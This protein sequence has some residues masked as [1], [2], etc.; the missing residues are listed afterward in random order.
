MDISFVWRQCSGQTARFG[1]DAPALGLEDAAPLSYGD[2]ATRA[3]SYANA[4]LE[5]GVGR[6]DRVALLLYNSVEYLLA[7]FAV[8]RIGAVAVRLNFR[9][10]GEELEYVLTDSGSTVLLA[11]AELLE[12]VEPV[13]A[14]LPVRAYVAFPSQDAATPAWASEWSMLERGSADEPRVR[15]P[16]LDE[17]AMLMY[18]SGTTGRPKGALWSHGTTAWFGAMQ[19]AEWG[20]GPETVLMV[21]GPLYHV[22]A[23]EDFSLPTMV[24]GGRVILMRSG[25]FTVDRALAIASEQGVTDLGI[26]PSMIYQWLQSPEA[27]QIDLSGVKR[28]FTGGDPL[29]PWAAEEIRERYGWMDLV[30]VYGL[31]EGTPVATCTGPGVA[32]ER[33]GTVGRPLPFCEIT[34]RDDAGAE[35]PEGTEAEI[36]TRS[37]AVALEYWNNPDANA[38]TFVDGW[39]RTGDLGR[40]E[41][42]ELSITGRKKDM[43]RSGGEN[44]YPAEIEDVLLRHPGIADA[45]VV[46]VPDPQFIETVCAV[47]VVAPGQEVSERDVVEHCTRHLA[48]YKKPRVVRFVD[49]LPRTAS[50]KVQKYL[51]RERF[52]QVAD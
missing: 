15:L 30:Q 21:T 12:R 2:L 18:T 39:C 36:W 28:L 47:V 7:Y 37:P 32:L 3:R 46:G 43:I 17:P 35:V 26:F 27:G 52:A 31:T 38:A 50:Q 34:L 20:F 49:E 44:I 42:G 14:T 25:G 13:R 16:S 4:L 41:D 29:L 19:L 51:L 24:V 5:L 1:P 9:L 8:T 45:A 10:T 33:P 48:G 23:F 22:G 6:G 40:I 11:D